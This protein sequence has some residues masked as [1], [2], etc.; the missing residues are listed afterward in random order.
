MQRMQEDPADFHRRMD[1][2]MILRRMGINGK[3]QCL[4][5]LMIVNRVYRAEC[6][7]YHSMI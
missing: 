5:H 1:G 3:G 2:R 7:Q 6:C 4:L